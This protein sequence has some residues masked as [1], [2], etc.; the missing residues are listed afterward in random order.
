MS[1]CSPPVA[2]SRRLGQIRISARP[3]AGRSRH[4]GGAS[5]QGL[6]RRLLIDDLNLRS[7]ARRHRRR[8]RAQRAGKTTLFRMI[9]RQEKPE[10]GALKVGETVKLGYVDQSRDTLNA[11]R[12]VWRKSPTGETRSSWARPRCRGRSYVASFNFKAPTA[13]EGSALRRRAQPR[14]SGQDVEIGPICCCWT[15]RP[16]ISN[17]DK[18]YARW[19]GLLDFA[20]SAMVISHDR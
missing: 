10:G 4:R 2:S 5:A 6:W 18:R 17:V 7:A 11:T 20:G 16:T 12:T 19:R 9:V 1:S 15:N 14:P 3:A 13:E 8:H